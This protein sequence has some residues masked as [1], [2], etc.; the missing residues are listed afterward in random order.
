MISMRNLF[1]SPNMVAEKSF[2]SDDNEGVHITYGAAG[3]PDTAQ[4]GEILGLNGNGDGTHRG[5]KSRHLQLIAL[6]WF[7]LL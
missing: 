7:P 4:S 5:L 3:R 1:K 2:R 6:G